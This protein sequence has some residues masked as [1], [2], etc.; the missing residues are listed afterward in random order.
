MNAFKLVHAVINKSDQFQLEM[1]DLLSAMTLTVSSE[2]AD[3][4]IDLKQIPAVTTNHDEQSLLEVIQTAQ[5]SHIQNV[6]LVNHQLLISLDRQLMSQ[7]LLTQ[8]KTEEW[9]LQTSEQSLRFTVDMSSPNLG[10]TM[11]LTHLRSTTVGEALSLMIEAAGHKVYRLNH[12]GDWGMAFAR[13]IVAVRR[14]GLPDDDNPNIGYSKLQHHFYEE[15]E[16]NPELDIEAAVVFN[17]LT[18]KDPKVMAEWK[19]ICE[20]SRK[21]F[22]DVYDLMNVHFTSETGE[23]AYTEAALE[24]KQQLVD[25]NITSKEL[26]AIIIHFPEKEIPQAL[27]QTGENDSL[28]L[29]R[30]LAAAIDRHEKFHADYNWYVVGNEQATHFIQLKRILEML[31]YDWANTISHLGIGFNSY[32]GRRLINSSGELI[33]VNG[34]FNKVARRIMETYQFSEEEALRYSLGTIIFESVKYPRLDHFDIDLSTIIANEQYNG[35]SLMYYVETFS[36]YG[37]PNLSV[38]Q[39]LSKEQWELLHLILAYP[40]K[41]AQGFQ[42]GEPSELASFAYEIYLKHKNLVSQENNHPSIDYIVIKTLKNLLY[43]LNIPV[44]D[45]I[46]R[47]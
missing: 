17:Q 7:E 40:Q 25:S 16:F 22:D 37:E 35:F 30:D 14:W 3:I 24:V 27:I 36:L 47:E 12:I 38:P 13:L 31:G 1:S 6:I 32:Q 15:S 11:T 2:T 8:A 34:L 23:S 41:L 26:D 42:R 10:R 4:V 28:Y 19:Q 45:T 44:K 21:R 9:D 33:S 29:T 18:H 46:G 5:D 39:R 20:I 43:V